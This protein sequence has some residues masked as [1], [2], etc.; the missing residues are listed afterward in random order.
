MSPKSL[1]VRERALFATLFLLTLVAVLGPAV[2]TPGGVAVHF[3]DARSWGALPNAMDVMSNLPFA[4][5]A[6]W[7]LYRLHR[8]DRAH[9]RS[10][11]VQTGAWAPLT[12]PPASALDC[13]WLFFA[14]LLITAAGS[15]FYHLQPDALRLGA[16]R[17]GM[18]VA[19]AG[20]MGFAVC[21]RVSQRAGWPVAWFVLAAGLMSV[22]VFHET[23][24]VLP[25]A[26]L[27]FGGMV[28]VLVLSFARPVRGAIGLK[29]GWVILFYSLAKMFELADE[30]VYEGTWHLISGHS[31][32]HLTAA[33]AALPVLQAIGNATRQVLRHNSARAAAAA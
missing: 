19:F 9:E 33:L 10:L 23:G 18:A 17:A 26:V 32:K 5:M 31:V 28:V 6:V 16:D 25:W 29:L 7:G 1:D 12:E 2:A 21:E 15:A 30:A 24:N 14:G 22:A 20:L 4:V 3:A 11:R 13:A 27:Q 8:V